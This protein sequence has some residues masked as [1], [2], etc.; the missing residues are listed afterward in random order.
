MHK[1]SEIIGENR[2]PIVGEHALILFEAAWKRQNAF[3]L[4]GRSATHQWL[5]LIGWVA[6]SPSGSVC[7]RS[8]VGAIANQYGWASVPCSSPLDMD[9]KRNLNPLLACQRG[10]LT[11]E[12]WLF[13]QGHTVRRS[14]W[15]SDPVRN[16]DWCSAQLLNFALESLV[17]LIT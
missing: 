10:C 14:Y 7:E 9:L 1:C 4:E 3:H 8:I 2:S 16:S 15:L 11:N 13:S 12:I 17:N 5:S 6:L